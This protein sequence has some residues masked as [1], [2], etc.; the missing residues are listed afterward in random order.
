[1]VTNQPAIVT[2]PPAPGPN[3]PKD[4]GPAFEVIG[5]EQNVFKIKNNNESLHGLAWQFDSVKYKETRNQCIFS[6]SVL[7]VGAFDP[8]SII[9]GG[10]FDRQSCPGG[11]EF[12]HKSF[13]SS[14]A[15][16]FALGED[17]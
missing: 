15:Q 1:M 13:K 8:K 14:N 11:G 9:N 3:S 10:A 5:A 4:L 17:V 6:I 7:G 2:G 12:D 16:G